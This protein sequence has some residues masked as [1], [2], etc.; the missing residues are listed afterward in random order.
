ML[1]FEP[2]NLDDFDSLSLGNSPLQRSQPSSAVNHETLPA[3]VLELLTSLNSS[4]KQLTQLEYIFNSIRRAH[5]EAEVLKCGFNR[6]TAKA[7]TWLMKNTA[8]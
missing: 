4:A 1:Q 2:L 8:M 7:I 3:D 5:Q 6:G